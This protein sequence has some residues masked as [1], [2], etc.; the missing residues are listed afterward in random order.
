[1]FDPKGR[2]R[3]PLFQFDGDLEFV[4]QV[5]K[6]CEVFVMVLQFVCE[7]I[8]IFIQQS[9]DKDVQKREGCRH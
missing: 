3:S 2:F 5:V 6:I 4:H 7:F 1:M 9:G 8:R